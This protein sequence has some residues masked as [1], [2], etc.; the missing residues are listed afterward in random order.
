MSKSLQDKLDAVALDLE[1][2]LAEVLAEL[3]KE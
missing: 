3:D 1:V 2:V